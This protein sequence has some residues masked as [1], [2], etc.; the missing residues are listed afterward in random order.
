MLRGTRCRAQ[1]SLE[2][3]TAFVLIFLLLFG[4]VNL[5]RWLVARMFYRQQIYENSRVQASYSN[6]GVEDDERNALRLR[7]F[8]Q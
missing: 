1:I 4:S 8:G 5:A 3:G 2:L 6:L 7:F